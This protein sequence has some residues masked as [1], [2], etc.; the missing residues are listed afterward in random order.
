ME[1]RR[2]EEVLGLYMSS[3]G[4]SAIYCDIATKSFMTNQ[5]FV[6]AIMELHLHHDWI[7]TRHCY[8][9]SF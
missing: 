2:Y 6:S 9:L 7:S 1:L 4:D 8:F 5:C 3:I